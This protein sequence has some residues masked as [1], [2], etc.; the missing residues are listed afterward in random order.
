VDVF[1][2]LAE[3]SV[4]ITGFSSLI[5][6]FRGSSTDWNRQDY[7]SFG[8]VLSWSIGSIFLSLLPIVLVEFGMKLSAA[9]QIGLLSTP[10]YMFTAGGILGYARNRIVREGDWQSRPL[11]RSAI[12][13]GRIGIGMSLSALVIVTGALAAGLRLL[14]GPPHA[15]FAATIVLL[16]L[17]A[18][19][20][21]G[22][23]VLRTARQGSLEESTPVDA[24]ALG[25]S[26][27]E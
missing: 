12:G 27:R 3:I 17:H 5:I 19:A 11:W 1:H 9:A 2:T 18:I 13:P 21:M 10:A 20:E 26:D 23:F 14:P 4:A 8:Y 6:I 7:L 22:V 15:W 16:M 24:E 25:G